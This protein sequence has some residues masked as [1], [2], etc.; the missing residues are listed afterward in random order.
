M[1]ILIITISFLFICKEYILASYDKDLFAGS[2][3]LH[4]YIGIAEGFSALS[5]WLRYGRGEAQ[6][7]SFLEYSLL[8]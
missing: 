6:A 7:C 4:P 1:S 8:L 2:D 5:G 3:Q